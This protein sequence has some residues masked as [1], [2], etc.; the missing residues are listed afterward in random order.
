MNLASK[1][2][3]DHN[4]IQLGFLLKSVE[5]SLLEYKLY[6]YIGFQGLLSLSVQLGTAIGSTGF[7]VRPFVH[8]W[9]IAAGTAF[10]IGHRDILQIEVSVVVV[11]TFDTGRNKKPAL[12]AGLLER[13]ERRLQRECSTGTIGSGVTY[14]PAITNKR[15]KDDGALKSSL[16][17]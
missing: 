9:R 2:F 11:V 14:K 13:G 6:G 4:S 5:V 8:K 10:C 16:S 3:V 12:V 7:T 17:L 1:Q 15:V